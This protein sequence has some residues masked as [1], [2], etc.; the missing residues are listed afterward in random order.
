MSVLPLFLLGAAFATTDF[1][2]QTE[3]VNPAYQK[4]L[5]RD[6]KEGMERLGVPGGTAAVVIDG[7]LVA[8][9]AG[10]IRM[11]GSTVTMKVDDPMHTASITRGMTALLLSRLDQQKVLPWTTTLAQAFPQMGS[12]HADYQRLSLLEVA[13]QRSG[14]ADIPPSSFTDLALLPVEQAR[15]TYAERTLS[16]E[17][18]TQPGTEFEYRNGNFLILG[19]AI[20]L[21]TDRTW[22]EVMRAEV[23]KP[24]NMKRAGFGPMGTGKGVVVP[25][26]HQVVEG[27]VVPV[28]RD[29]PPFFG[30]AGTVHCSVLDLLNYAQAWV[31]GPS[32]EGDYL[33]PTIWRMLETPPIGSRYGA[34]IAV[35]DEA[36]GGVRDM[37][38]GGSNTLSS[39][40]WRVR[41]KGRL[42]VAT[43]LNRSSPGAEKLYDRLEEVASRWVDATPPPAPKPIADVDTGENLL[44]GVEP[45]R[46]LNGKAEGK[47]VQ[48]PEGYRFDVIRTDEYPFQ[49]SMAFLCRGLD[50]GKKYAVQFEAMS[51]ATRV[52]TVAVE[53][54]DRPFD[55]CGLEEKFECG[56]QWKPFRF[57]LTPRN[58][59][60]AATR[61]PVF[62]LGNEKGSFWCRN[63]RVSEVKG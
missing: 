24:L 28:Y 11:L 8:A 30:P 29:V 57:V 37:G 35:G 20:E 60:G 58:L 56:P 51:P 55:N 44:K 6:L 32:G 5:E 40:D 59:T 10:G 26:Q 39:A 49:V 48:K 9:A 41:R 36:V 33:S 42:I 17:P 1:N 38:H 19:A 52:V 61:A 45:I 63:V 62:F 27:K 21:A 31:E 4:T 46:L 54:N 34:G 3:G 25:W 14:V 50:E 47:L 23:F 22:E 16:V 7:K 13:Y 53:Q 43:M 12:M 2:T 18:E 15:A